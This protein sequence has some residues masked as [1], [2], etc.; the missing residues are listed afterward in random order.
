MQSPL[1]DTVWAVALDG[2]ASSTENAENVP[3]VATVAALK[4]CGVPPA[5]VNLT[6]MVA[7]PL[8]QIPLANVDEPAVT[9][10]GLKLK[11]LMIN[12][13]AAG[14]THKTMAAAANAELARN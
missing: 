7:A 4:V 5:S 2:M 11:E 3:V 14:V 1:T 8:T 13:A 12:P 10:F 9:V 6:S